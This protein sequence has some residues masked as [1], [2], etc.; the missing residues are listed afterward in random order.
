MIPLLPL[1]LCWLAGA[2]LVAVDGRRRWATGLAAAVLGGVAALDIALLSRLVT[3]ADAAPFEVVTGGWPAGVGIR[4]R[5]DALTLFFSAIVALVLLAVTLHERRAEV[6]SRLF[7]GLLLWLAAGLHGAFATADL[8]NFYVFFEVSVITSFVLASYGY[9]RAELRAAFVYVA[10]NLLGSVVFLIGVAGIYFAR[11]TLDLSALAAGPGDDAATILPATLLFVALALK[12]GLFPFHGWVPVLYSHARPAVVAALSGALVHLG[13]YGILRLGFGVFDEARDL[14]AGVLVLLGAVAAVYGGLIA[15]QRQRPTEIAAYAA[16][17]HAGYLV[18]ALGIGGA[19]GT[20]A[21]LLLVASG[22]V[23]KAVMFLSLEGRDPWRSTASLIAAASK[24]GMPLTLGFLAKAQLF[25]ASLEA[26]VSALVVPALLLSSSLVLA[27]VFRFW[28]RLRQRPAPPR[29]RGAA[30]VGLALVGVAL[31]VVP[32]P[33][34]EVATHVEA[35]PLVAAGTGRSEKDGGRTRSQMAN[36]G[37]ETGG[38]ASSAKARRA[39]DP[40]DRRTADG[41]LLGAGR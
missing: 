31:G 27:S 41:D 35:A 40:W 29:A 13:A 33:V 12:L 19:A 4:L 18:L 38:D 17:V 10:V 28:L 22:S 14:G 23:D 3:G 2:L 36:R 9:G 21:V 32:G 11:G 24:S 7:P 30:A 20:S 26:G 34:L 39:S 5:V 1:V 6:R 25:R 8:F 16:I 15:V 37:D